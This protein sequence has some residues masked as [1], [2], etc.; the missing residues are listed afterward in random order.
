[1]SDFIPPDGIQWHEGMLLSPQHFQ[2]M[3]LRQEAL[4]H[5]HLGAIQP[6]H[7]GVR[8]L[9][10]DPSLLVDGTFRINDMVA[11]MPDALLVVHPSGEGDLELDLAPY[12]DEIMQHPMLVHVVVPA[13]KSDTPNRG[14]LARYESAEGPPT[15]DFNTG[16]TSVR[17]PRMRPRVGLLLGEKPSEKYVSFPV[18][19]IAYRNEALVLT[20][21]VPPCL[22]VPTGSVLGRRC[23]LLAKTLR[24][25]AVFL[26]ERL[27]GP[28]ARAGDPMVAETQGLIRGLVA[29]LPLFEASINTGVTHPHQIYLSLCNLLGNLA[30]VGGGFVPPALPP[31]NH[32]DL[33]GTFNRAL[34][35]ALRMIES[36]REAYVAIP[37]ERNEGRFELTIDKAWAGEYLIIGAR[38]K[39]GASE[40]EVA[41]WM[42]DALIGSEVVVPSMEE[43]R[44]SG[45]TRDVIEKDDALGLM[46]VRGV[47]LI[48]V[49]NDPAYILADEVLQV[50]NRGDPQ[51]E[52][53]PADLVL[54][55][56]NQAATATGSAK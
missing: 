23:A 52:N 4:L 25:K 29:G 13:L 54:Y 50:I 1:M 42:A 30:A 46:P 27:M 7:W 43:R 47:A 44:V 9:S 11:I 32:N 18:A 21:F 31:Y 39:P 16:E 49:A 14:D 37:F 53:G 38:G 8:Q 19:E 40:R 51:A 12:M 55:I 56:S 48:R 17:I 3:T 20:D 15:A 26:S 35:F 36:V 28:S 10:V 5:Y 2:Q 34:D 33:R 22:W 45:P 41:S 6:F 24:E